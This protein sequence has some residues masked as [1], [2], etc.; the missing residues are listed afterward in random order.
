LQ[1]KNYNNW[2]NKTSGNKEPSWYAN[3][4]E[5]SVKF[6]KLTRSIPSSSLGEVAVDVVIVGG[7]NCWY[8]YGISSFKVRKESYCN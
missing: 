6:A 1:E 5:E 8:D 4:E 2:E 3:I 7:W